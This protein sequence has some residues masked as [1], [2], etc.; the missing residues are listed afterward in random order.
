MGS[1]RVTLQSLNV[2]LNVLLS[3]Q[4]TK[5]HFDDK[6]QNLEEKVKGQEERLIEVDKKVEKIENEM[7]DNIYRI[8]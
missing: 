6:L 1:N 7:P 3:T 4:V 5:E 8:A 2:K